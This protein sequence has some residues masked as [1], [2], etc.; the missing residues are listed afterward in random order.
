MGC[1]SSCLWPAAELC[2]LKGIGHN[3]GLGANLIHDFFYCSWKSIECGWIYL[4]QVHMLVTWHWLWCNYSQACKENLQ[5]GGLIFR[6]RLWNLSM[7]TLNIISLLNHSKLLHLHWQSATSKLAWCIANMT[8]IVT[9]K[10]GIYC[11]LI[12]I[13]RGRSMCPVGPCMKLLNRCQECNCR[14]HS[15]NAYN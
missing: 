8:S 13:W 12:L 6:P 15:Q 5:A 14:G 10:G 4:S 2:W 7:A 1:L 3:L 11:I 9:L